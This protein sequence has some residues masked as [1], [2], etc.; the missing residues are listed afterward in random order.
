MPKYD[1]PVVE[2]ESKNHRC[3]VRSFNFGSSVKEKESHDSISTGYRPPTFPSRRGWEHTSEMESWDLCGN[4][5]VVS[6]SPIETRSSNQNSYDLGPGQ[7]GETPLQELPEVPR[8]LLDLL[9][10]DR[11]GFHEI[12]SEDSLDEVWHADNLEYF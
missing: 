10:D 2:T 8:Q 4:Q 7:N 12:T 9:K 1:K 6:S 5:P 11:F 3:I